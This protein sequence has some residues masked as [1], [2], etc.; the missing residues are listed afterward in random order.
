HRRPRKMSKVDTARF[1][2]TLLALR[3]RL[4]GDVSHLND[5]AFRARAEAEGTGIA[6]AA[7][8][9]EQALDT[10]EHEFTLSLLHNQEQTLEEIAGPR[11]GIDRGPFA[12]GEEARGRI[13]RARWQA[14]PYPR[15]CVSSARKLQ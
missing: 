12:G 7:T 8:A 2:E 1:R 14:P 3:R 13:P 9:G 15:H 11:D 10:Y 4:T 6:A 5:E